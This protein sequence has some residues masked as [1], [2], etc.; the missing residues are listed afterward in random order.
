MSCLIIAG[1]P[2]GQIGLDAIDSRMIGKGVLGEW[3]VVIAGDRKGLVRDRPDGPAA[4]TETGDRTA[5][6]PRASRGR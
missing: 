3:D 5:D 1:D 6:G 4:R 2:C